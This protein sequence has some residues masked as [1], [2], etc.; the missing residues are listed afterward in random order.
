MYE[1]GAASLELA[2]L[3]R[4]EISNFS[5]PGRESAHNLNYWEQGEYL[6]LGPSAASYLDGERRA[7]TAGTA[8]YVKAAMAGGPIPLQYRETLTGRAKRAERIMLG[9]RRTSGIELPDDIFIEFKEEIERLS[10]AGLVERT[11][12][13]L[14]IKEDRL[15]VAN[16]VFREFV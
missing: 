15:Y 9:L 5:L 1:M 7:N 2:G 10:A 13:R 6:G 3:G 4:Y 11:G 8:A 16:A 12:A 14:S